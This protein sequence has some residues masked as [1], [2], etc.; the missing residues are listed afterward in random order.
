MR[1]G[2]KCRLRAFLKFQHTAF[3]V[4]HRYG[5]LYGGHKRDAGVGVDF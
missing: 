2:P 4:L 3:T 1:L 5:I